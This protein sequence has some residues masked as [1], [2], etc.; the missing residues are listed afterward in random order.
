MPARKTMYGMLALQAFSNYVTRG[1][2]APMIQFIVAD[3][4]LSLEQKA[5][6]LGAFFPVFTPFQVV[7]G[8][9]CQIFG[10]KKL[11]SLNLFG[12]SSLLLLLPTM[13]RVRGIVAM[14]SCLAGI[15]ICQ[16]VLVPAQGQMKRNW[17][18]DGPERV[19]GQRIIGLGM[20]VG[21]PTAAAA[22]PWIANRYGWRAVPYTLGGPMAV[23]S[24]IWHFFAT[25]QPEPEQD[26]LPPPATEEPKKEKAME[27]RIFS[28][29]AIQGAMACHIAANNLGY[30]FL[31]WAPTYYNEVLKVSNVVAGWLISFPVRGAGCRELYVC[32][33]FPLSEKVVGR[34]P[35][36]SGCHSLLAPLRTGCVT[37]D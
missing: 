9:L 17:L 36:E 4:A 25:E 22:I 13:A 29:P 14:C 6:L 32:S 12:M 21:Y 7:A 33:W 37:R 23:F 15:G 31:Q 19:W 20:R 5:L 18:P 35:S 26:D 8:P 24:L 27:W 28:V 34:V 10:G 1:A 2:L 16:G 11:L 30:C 3:L